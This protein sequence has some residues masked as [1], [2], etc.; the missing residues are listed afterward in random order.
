V[1][2]SCVVLLTEEI[3]LSVAL[4]IIHRPVDLVVLQAEQPKA[5]GRELQRLDVVCL[6]Q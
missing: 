1:S 5:V 3:A 4:R 2:C 6:V